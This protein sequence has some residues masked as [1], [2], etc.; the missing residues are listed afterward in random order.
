[1]IMCTA[2]TAIFAFALWLPTSSVAATI[3]YSI[4]FGFTSGGYISLMPVLVGRI[5]KLEEFG[6]RYGTVLI[7]ASIAYILLKMSDLIDRSLT[8]VP[9]G[10]A[11]IGDSGT[12]YFGLI[13]WTG[14]TNI[15][16]AFFFCL[17]RWKVGGRS[18][19]KFV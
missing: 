3:A 15:I 16:A 7:F 9:I 4:I 1:M 8:G 2:S 5:S 6:T 13:I 11:L 18:I 10:G 14:V 12:N 17:A 19:A